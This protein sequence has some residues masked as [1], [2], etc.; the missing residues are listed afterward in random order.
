MEYL[1]SVKEMLRLRLC[2]KVFDRAVYRIYD[3][4]LTQVRALQA[5]YEHQVGLYE[6]DLE[7]KNLTMH[8]ET[9]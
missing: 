7:I 2:A 5:K 9:L 1:P 3:T 8:L 6:H 4:K